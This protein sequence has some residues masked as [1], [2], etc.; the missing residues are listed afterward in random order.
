M[1][2]ENIILFIIV[3]SLF[4]SEFKKGLTIQVALNSL[5]NSSFSWLSFGASFDES[6]YD[7]KNGVTGLMGNYDG[8]ASN[9]IYYQNGTT[10][11]GITAESVTYAA[12]FTCKTIFKLLLFFFFKNK[13]SF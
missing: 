5:A 3:T 2:F 12:S 1:V 9:D 7:Y 10:L 4:K 11:N 8:I 6:V 13:I